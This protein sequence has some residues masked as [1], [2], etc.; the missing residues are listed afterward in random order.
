MSQLR[1]GYGTVT[2]LDETAYIIVPASLPQIVDS[3]RIVM[4]RAY[5]RFNVHQGRSEPVADLL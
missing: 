1:A 3:A 2:A 4:K 5:G